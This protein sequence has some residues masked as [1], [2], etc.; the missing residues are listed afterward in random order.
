MCKDRWLGSLTLVRMSENQ[1]AGERCI[2]SILVVID[3]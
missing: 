2:F 3:G 1:R